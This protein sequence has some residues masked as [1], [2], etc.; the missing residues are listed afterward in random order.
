MEF[1]F[2]NGLTGSR[3]KFTG[4]LEEA[5]ELVTQEAYFY[6]KNPEEF[7]CLECDGYLGFCHEKDHDGSKAIIIERIKK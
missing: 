6:F 5:E 4:T 3:K 7:G 1:I 2:E